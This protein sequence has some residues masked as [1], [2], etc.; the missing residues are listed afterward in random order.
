MAPNNLFDGITRFRLPLGESNR[1]LGS[2]KHTISFTSSKR[3]NAVRTIRR[4]IEHRAAPINRAHFQAAHCQP[5][6]A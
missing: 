1:K 2:L 3:I 4:T 5:K 6:A